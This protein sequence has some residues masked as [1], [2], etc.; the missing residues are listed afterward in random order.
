VSMMDRSVTGGQSVN[1]SDQVEYTY[2]LTKNAE[3]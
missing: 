3:V 2:Q 1:S